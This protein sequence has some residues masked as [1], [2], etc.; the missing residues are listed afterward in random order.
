ME[1]DLSGS[2]DGVSESKPR[3][4]RE[5]EE[6]RG[7][8]GRRGRLTGAYLRMSQSGRVI[9]KLLS[10]HN[11]QTYCILY[12]CLVLLLALL[13]LLLLLLLGTQYNHMTASMRARR[14][15]AAEWMPGCRTKPLLV[16]SGDP[17]RR[18]PTNNGQLFQGG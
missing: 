16:Y 6:K 7:R 13:L 2:G 15:L 4:K 18:S 11:V 12:Y 3:E 9:S 17:K 14:W 1:G 5:R 8:E 10:V